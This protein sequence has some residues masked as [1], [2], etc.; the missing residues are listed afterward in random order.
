MNDSL[1]N[2]IS[3]VPKKPGVYQFI[4]DKGEIIY[5]GKAKDLRVRVRSYFQKNKYQTPKNQS[6]IKRISDLDWIVVYRCVCIT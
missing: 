6:M 1:K 5:I 3:N 2:R 4:N